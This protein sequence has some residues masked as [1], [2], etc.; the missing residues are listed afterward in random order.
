MLLLTNFFMYLYDL[1]RF[2]HSIQS[3][4]RFRLVTLTF[5]LFFFQQTKCNRMKLIKPKYPYQM[6][7]LL[8]YLILRAK[9]RLL[10]ITLEFTIYA[11]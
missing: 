8:T 6:D 4:P 7:T 10:L 5:I 9:K 11:I 1:G 3:Y 2:S